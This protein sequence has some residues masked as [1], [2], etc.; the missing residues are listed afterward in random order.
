MRS[1]VLM[2]GRIEGMDREDRCDVLAVKEYIAQSGPPL[3]SQCCVLEAPWDL[4]DGTYRVTFDGQT[5]MATRQDGLWLPG[6]TA[7][8]AE[9]EDDRA[10]GPA[11]FDLPELFQALPLLTPPLH[12]SHHRKR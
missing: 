1:V 6:E 11:S 5:V 10:P 7:I 4:P 9:C 8:P 2:R 3:Y 12:F